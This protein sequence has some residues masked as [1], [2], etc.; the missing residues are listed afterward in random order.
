MS[1]RTTLRLLAAALLAAA[2]TPPGL[3]AQDK[4]PESPARLGLP[5]DPE[6]VPRLVL[7]SGLPIIHVFEA[8]CPSEGGWGAAALAAL[9]EAAETDTVLRSQLANTLGARVLARDLC[10]SDLPRFESWLADQ[11]HRQ[12]GD[13]S[14][15]DEEGGPGE[16]DENPSTWPFVLLAYIGLSQDSATQALVRNIAMDSTVTDYWRGQAAQTMITQRYGEDLAG[17]DVA[18]RAKLH[19]CGHPKWHG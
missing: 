4:P 9:E 8:D 15:G 17:K 19:T 13:G 14:M 16:E 1:I 5:E 2:G 7:A 11:L 12:W 3:A 10:L 6:E 18:G